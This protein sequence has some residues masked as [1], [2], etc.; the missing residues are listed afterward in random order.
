MKADYQVHVG[1]MRDKEIDF[2][3]AKNKKTLFLQVAFNLE[4]QSTFDREF[5]N[6]LSLK[7]NNPKAIVTMDELPY[8]EKEGV[9]FIPA[10]VLDEYLIRIG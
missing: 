10:W 5:S 3:A 7:N 9:D 6:L 1:V 8:S 2:V 4:A